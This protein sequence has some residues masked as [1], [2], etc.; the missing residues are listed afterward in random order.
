MSR[1][2]CSILLKLWLTI[3]L[4]YTK[5]ISTVPSYLMVIM[6]EKEN[7]NCDIY[8]KFDGFAITGNLYTLNMNNF[9]GGNVLG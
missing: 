3:G 4:E 5:A 1:E 7:P 2:N 9:V 6:G 8:A